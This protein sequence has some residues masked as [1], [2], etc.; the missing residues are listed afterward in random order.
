M[1]DA[2]EADIRIIDVT[3]DAFIV[4]TEHEL[5]AEFYIREIETLTSQNRYEL[6]D[7]HLERLNDRRE[8][9]DLPILRVAT[10]F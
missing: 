1:N 2:S 10:D 9:Q 8:A 6:T 4:A 7:A 3:G 5:D